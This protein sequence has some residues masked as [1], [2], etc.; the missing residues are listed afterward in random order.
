MET[1]ELPTALIL[2]G[3]R[4]RRL[5]PLSDEL[6]KPLLRI[7][8][9]CVLQEILK[10]LEEQGVRRSVL[11]TGYKGEMIE[12]Q[13]GSSFGRMQLCY[14]KE[15]HPMGSAGC[16]L[17]AKDLVQERFFVI[18]ADA[19]GVRDYRGMARAHLEKGGV[20][21][22][23]LTQVEDPVEYG[24]VRTD[25]EGA[26]LSF[27]EKPSWST[28]FT[29]LANTG[30]YLLEREILDL[31][32]ADRSFDFG[33]DLFPLLLQSGKKLY[34]Y[35]DQRPWCDIGDLA[36]YLHCN[37]RENGG[38]TVV[39]PRCTVSN[40]T[41]ERS[42]VLEGSV[43]GEGSVIRGSIVGKNCTIG[44]NCVLEQG[45]VLGHGCVLEEGCH[46]REGTVLSCGSM[47]TSAR[48]AQRVAPRL[49]GLFEENELCI[50]EGRE[51]E[52]LFIRLGYT[53]G[54]LAKQRGLAVMAEDVPSCRSFK[55]TL[56]RGA[57]LAGYA[58]VD[59]GTGFYTMAGACAL[60]GGYF[61]TVL[62]TTQKTGG[63]RLYFL[64]RTGL[65]AGAELI[66]K[67]RDAFGNSVL[68]GRVCAPLRFASRSRALYEET[69]FHGV[70]L[71]GLTVGMATGT[72]AADFLKKGL[73][74]YGARVVKE[75]DARLVLTLSPDGRRAALQE[76]EVGLDF[77]HLCA[78]HLGTDLRSG[79]PVHALPHRAPRVL[80]EMARRYG[81]H[82]KGYALCPGASEDAETR[83]QGAQLR[84]IH[85]GCFSAVRALSL[86]ASRGLNCADLERLLPPFSVSEQGMDCEKEE[87]LALLLAS[88]GEPGGEG[89][90]VAVQNGYLRIRAKGGRGLS[91]MAEAAK[92]Q[93]A[94]EL[95][96]HWRR[97]L[98]S[99]KSQVRE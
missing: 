80:F 71:I 65:A 47:L 1:H 91:L 68:C 50:K 12:A 73:E 54:L 93:D 28:V 2:A 44:K 45:C 14:I 69:L 89:V 30:I 79:Q 82:P 39:E 66:R 84:Y 18:C 74:Q 36:T 98:L 3:G 32:P 34:G 35:S 88:R 24:L 6:P 67:V 86:M 78:L 8:G 23:M 81:S 15:K 76:G 10:N 9:R 17:C 97:E 83:W 40:A 77:W 11:L 51:G 57:G 21:T 20:A 58:P 55:E 60:Q 59:L 31:I 56:L 95:L 87:K 38:K 72:P 48:A 4:G 33:K 25:P 62:I 70:S 96:R 22:L 94:E 42:L 37:L 49:T 63:W 27:T 5:S 64:D 52:E 43:I 29:N 13:F 19:W 46:L 85:D 61:I 92:E 75:S 16:V 53:L 7:N 41:L 99:K 90:L 26:I